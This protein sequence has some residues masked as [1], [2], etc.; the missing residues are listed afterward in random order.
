LL[1]LLLLLLGLGLPRGRRRI[2]SGGQGIKALLCSVVVL[3]F[4]LLRGIKGLLLQ[5]AVQG[6]RRGRGWEK[7][8]LGLLVVLQGLLG[9]GLLG[10]GGGLKLAVAQ[11]VRQGGAGLRQEGKVAARGVNGS[12]GAVA[13]PLLLRPAVIARGGL[14]AALKG[15]VAQHIASGRAQRRP[16]KQHGSVGH[17]CA[18][19]LD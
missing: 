5:L 12:G 6:L 1:L 15:R 16:R 17:F 7:V 9:Q 19:R 14:A 3:R 2:P 13:G 11:G 8:L 18:Q 10:Q 4:A